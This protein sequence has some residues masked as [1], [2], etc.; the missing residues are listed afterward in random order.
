M[1]PENSNQNIPITII[2]Q[3]QKRKN[4]DSDRLSI[5]PFIKVKIQ[6]F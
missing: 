1:N 4:N 6:N 3:L 2:K 5:D